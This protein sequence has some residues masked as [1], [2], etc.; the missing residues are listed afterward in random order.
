MAKL[1]KLS[2]AGTALITAG[3][4]T[5]VASGL[6]ITA[7]AD[8]KPQTKTNNVNQADQ[9]KKATNKLDN[10]SNKQAQLVNMLLASKAEAQVPTQPGTYTKSVLLLDANGKQLGTATLTRVVNADGSSNSTLSKS[11]PGGYML[12]DV[13]VLNHYPSAIT[14]TPTQGAVKAGTTSKQAKLVDAN[15]KQIASICI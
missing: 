14:L 8:A 12:K 6:T 1:S 11:I 15:G 3:G 13:S 10:A 2:L 7:H 5:T 9:L 4:L